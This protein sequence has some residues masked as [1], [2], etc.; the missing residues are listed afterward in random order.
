MKI[1]NQTCPKCGANLKTTET[2]GSAFC[3]Y[4]GA[5]VI[6]DDE[7]VHVQYDNAEEAGYSFEKGRQRAI[8]ETAAVAHQPQKAVSSSGKK[9]VQLPRG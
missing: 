9:K 5:E 1:I 2:G 3:E 7:K 6:L 8:A 4:C